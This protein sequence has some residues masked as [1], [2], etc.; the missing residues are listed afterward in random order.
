MS[1]E[2]EYNKIKGLTLDEAREKLGD[3]LN[4]HRWYALD[5]ALFDH[6]ERFREGSEPDEKKVEIQR[7]LERGRVT[8][9]FDEPDTFVCIASNDRG[10]GEAR[11]AFFFFYDEDDIMCVFHFYREDVK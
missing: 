2:D 11:A 1:E 5:H 8:P 7:V 6:P 9:N 4:N 10:K 3:C